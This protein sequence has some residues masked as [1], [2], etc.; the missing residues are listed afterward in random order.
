MIMTIVIIY[1][2]YLMWYLIT[3]CK[4][5]AAPIYSPPPP[6]PPPLKIQKLQSPLFANIENVLVHHPLQKEGGGGG[7]EDTDVYINKIYQTRF[8]YKFILYSLL[9]PKESFMSNFK[10]ARNKIVF[11]GATSNWLIY[12]TMPGPF[13]TF[14]TL[15]WQNARINSVRRAIVCDV[16]FFFF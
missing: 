15:K 4:L 13:R 16:P 9:Y 3:S 14:P 8:I 11:N 12:V 10:T 7:W 1:I 5:L 2:F 6:T